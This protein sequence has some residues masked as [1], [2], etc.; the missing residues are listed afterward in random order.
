M[1]GFKKPNLDQLPEQWSKSS[2]NPLLHKTNAN[3]Y[4]KLSRSVCFRT[5]EVNQGLATIWG[6]FIQEKLISLMNTDIKIL[7]N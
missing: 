3:T 7:G 1:L 2:K 4:K 6:V 5:L